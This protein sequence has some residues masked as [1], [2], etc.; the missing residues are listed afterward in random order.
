MFSLSHL[1]PKT[2]LAVLL[3]AA[4]TPAGAAI[5]FTDVTAESGVDY[6]QHEAQEQPN[7]LFFMGLLCEP[8]RISGGAAVADVDGDGH[9]DLFVTR[10]DAPDILF[11]NRGDG[12]FEDVSVA[13]GLA[14]YDLQSNGAVFADIDNDG[15]PDLFVTLLGDEGD[16]INDRNHLF[17]NDGRGHFQEEAVA[18][19]A[20]VSS[21][22]RRLNYSATA[23][24]YDR[25]GYLDIHVSEWFGGPHTRLLRNRGADAPGFFVDATEDAELDFTGVN[26]FA[27]SFVDLDGDGWQDLAIA[28]DFGSSRLYWNDGDG[29]FS[30][31]TVAA[32][33]GTDENGMGSTFGDFDADGDLDWFVTSIWDPDETCE[34]E[35]CNW[36]YSGNRL[37]RNEGGREFSDATD[38]AGVRVGYWGWGAVFFDADNDGDLDLVMTNGVDFPTPAP[39]PDLEEP[40]HD[41]P[42]R[43]WEND[44]TGAMTESS[45]AAGLD[46]TGPGKGLLT[47]DYDS[48]G[49]LDLFVVNNAGHPRL[50]RNDLASDD[51]W[52]RVR[53]R[54]ARRAPRGHGH[55][56]PQH[57]AGHHD[58]GTN[59]DGIGA[60]VSVWT[61]RGSD[62]QIREVG[63]ASHF[64]GQSERVLHFGLGPDVRRVWK[65]QVD[66]PASGARVVRHRVKTGRTV[67]IREHGRYCGL[68]GIELLLPVPFALAR[69]RRRAHKR[70]TPT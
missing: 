47:F 40:Y 60:R 46:D 18:R 28:A 67:L 22:V 38:A 49:D 64:L 65:V 31:G 63:V 32:H 21:A 30:D 39:D 53:V 41:D 36:L 6:L 14:D 59:R 48:D 8:E 68:L 3:A 57:A 27:S 16:P 33:V 37:Y 61:T 42:M 7:C 70:A 2:T 45:A 62:P 9:L 35:L 13:S 29:T 54:G 56:P 5:H 51:A 10:L 15:D 52:L 26:A 12:S 24:D 34:I 50:Y 23:G 66:F 58:A 43:L 19:G 4:A 17:I 25:D 1:L 44:G 11:R 55:G 20:D 69:R